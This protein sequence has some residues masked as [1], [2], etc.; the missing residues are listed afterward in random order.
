[1]KKFIFT[2]PE[3][4]HSTRIVIAET[5]EEAEAILKDG[6][7]FEQSRLHYSSLYP[8]RVEYFIPSHKELEDWKLIYG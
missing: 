7:Y 8:I 5:E 2:V 3:I 1:M 6:E 4:H